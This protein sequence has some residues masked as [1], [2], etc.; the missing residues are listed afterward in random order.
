MNNNNNFLD[1][2]TILSFY[3]QLQN[4]DELQKQST[5]DE[6]FEGLH[7]DII[8]LLQDNRKMFEKVIEQNDMILHKLEQKDVGD[9]NG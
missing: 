6:I 9:K 8:N 4:N 2:I 3:L 5:N 1:F 7:Q